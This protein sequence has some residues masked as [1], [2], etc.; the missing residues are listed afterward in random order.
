MQQLYISGYDE[1]PYEPLPSSCWAGSYLTKLT[2][3]HCVISV[4]AGMA[5]SLCT[6]RRLELYN[7][8]FSQ[9]ASQQS[10]ACCTSWPA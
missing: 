10:S 7:V 3:E 1:Q 8:A 9:A 5:A 6:L 2:L 4:P